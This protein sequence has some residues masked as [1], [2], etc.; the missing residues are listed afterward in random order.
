MTS[1][2]QWRSS[3]PAPEQDLDQVIGYLKEH[4]KNTPGLMSVGEHFAIESAERGIYNEF[5]RELGEEVDPD[6]P[7]EFPEIEGG[8]DEAS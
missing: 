5:C 1:N 7:F 3:R 6:A 4:L 2:S 8:D